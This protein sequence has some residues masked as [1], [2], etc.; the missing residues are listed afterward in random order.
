LS[1]GKINDNGRGIFCESALYTSQ[2]QRQETI[3]EPKIE[4][5]FPKKTL[6]SLSRKIKQRTTRLISQGNS[7]GDRLLNLHQKRAQA[8]AKIVRGNQRGPK[9]DGVEDLCLHIEGDYWRVLAFF[10]SKT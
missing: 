3:F 8:A 5:L 1:G 4:G 10:A 6:L 2:E 9:A 7:D